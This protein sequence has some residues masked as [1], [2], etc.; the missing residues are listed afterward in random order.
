VKPD[1]AMLADIKG[2]GDFPK[3]EDWIK[4]AMEKIL[5]GEAAATRAAA[6]AAAV[7]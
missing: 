7:R 6:A 5:R 3:N 1:D 2:Y 4:Q